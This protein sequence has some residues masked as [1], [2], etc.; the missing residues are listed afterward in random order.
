MIASFDI[1][2]KLMRLG[3]E[4]I[5]VKELLIFSEDV[6]IFFGNSFDVF[7]SSFSDN[8]VISDEL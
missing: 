7:V 5:L 6:D 8:F 4:V 2:L 1:L 3:V